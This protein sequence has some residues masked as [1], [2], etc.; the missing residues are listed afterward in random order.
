LFLTGQK[1][2]ELFKKAKDMM[3]DGSLE[4]SPDKKLQADLCSVRKVVTQQSIRVEFPVGPDGRHADFA[5]ALAKALSR[6]LLS[7]APE[8][9]SPDEALRAE[10]ARWKKQAQLEVMQRQRQRMRGLA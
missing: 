10:Q 2:F 3:A 7:P 6:S 4:L 1:Q 8:E 5:P 9:L